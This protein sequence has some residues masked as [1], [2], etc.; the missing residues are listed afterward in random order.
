MVLSAPIPFDIIDGIVDEFCND[1]DTLKATSLVSRNFLASSQRHIFC[2]TSLWVNYYMKDSSKSPNR[3]LSIFKMK[4]ELALHVRNFRLSTSGEGDPILHGS[5]KHLEATDTVIRELCRLL[6]NIRSLTLY[7]QWN[8]LSF[9]LR[10]AIFDL[11]KV[12][13]LHH[14]SATEFPIPHFAE[15]PQISRITLRG[16]RASYSPAVATHLTL[17]KYA[18]QPNAKGRLE[19]LEFQ[20]NSFN[21]YT[22]DRFSDTLTRSQSLLTISHLRVLKLNGGSMEMAKE[23]WEVMKAADKMLEIFCW[24]LVSCKWGGNIGS[25]TLYFV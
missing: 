15:L 1:L 20:H 22:M 24:D 13:N 17:P 6:K 10:S 7:T 19:I 21:D 14:I 9:T 16:P 23:A 2:N 8:F 3:L 5:L 12:P 18:I 25:G 4:P 11:C